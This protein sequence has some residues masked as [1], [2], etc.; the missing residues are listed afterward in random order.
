MSSIFNLIDKKVRDYERNAPSRTTSPVGNVTP[1][2][3]AAPDPRSYTPT[4]TPPA[5]QPQTE[6][7]SLPS[8]PDTDITKT[9]MRG[10]S[11][12][13][14]AKEDRTVGKFQPNSLPAPA[15]QPSMEDI[16]R[17]DSPTG[18]ANGEKYNQSAIFKANKT[19]ET[20]RE[21]GNMLSAE[22]KLSRLEA[23]GDT[24]SKEYF[25][26]AADYYASLEKL[27][28]NTAPAA[29]KKRHQWQNEVFPSEWEWFEEYYRKNFQAIASPKDYDDFMSHYESNPNLPHTPESDRH[30]ATWK[31]KYVSP[32]VGSYGDTYAD[33]ATMYRDMQEIMSLPGEIS[34]LFA[35]VTA[36]GTTNNNAAAS[37]TGSAY[38]KILAYLEK[39]YG[40]DGAAEKTD[41]L[42]SSFTRYANEQ[43]AG[44]RDA[45]ARAAAN[46][47][48]I[49][50]NAA[51]VAAMLGN[52]VTAPIGAGLD[53]VGRMTGL[54]DS[55]YKT[56][57]T[58]LPAYALGDFAGSVRSQTAENIENKVSGPLGEGLSFV[59]N[60]GMSGLD[61]LTRQ[62]IAQAVGFPGLS[63]ALAGSQ[64][65]A[66]GYRDASARG[67]TALQATIMGLA[68]GALE[69]ITEEWSIERLMSLKDMASVKDVVVQALLKSPMSEISEEEL[70]EIG[71]VVADAIFMGKNSKDNI[72]IRNAMA[73]G[74]TYGE[75]VDD[76]W[77]EHGKDL[78]M[79]AA[80][81]YLSTLV[82][83]GP[84]AVRSGAAISRANNVAPMLSEAARAA[85]NAQDAFA[86]QPQNGSLDRAIS[87][88]VQGQEVRS[89][90]EEAAQ[91]RQK[92]DS[93]V[94]AIRT[95]GTV[96]NSVVNS[97]MADNAAMDYLQETAGTDLTAAVTN[98]PNHTAIRDAISA[99]ANPGSTAYNEENTVTGGNKNGEETGAAQGAELYRTSGE[100]VRKL[101]GGSGDNQVLPEGRD[102][103][104]ADIRGSGIVLLSD[105]QAGK[106]NEAGY[107]GAI[108]HQADSDD[109][110][111]SYVD[112]LNRARAD[113]TK[114]GWAVSPKTFEDANQPG[115]KVLL[116]DDGSSG[117]IVTPDG[118][119]E[120]VFANKTAGAKKGSAKYIIA[121][122]VAAGGTKL[123]CYGPAL[124]K[125]YA[126]Y[127][128]VPAS[129]LGFNAEYANDGW[130]ESKGSPDVITMYLAPG[131]TAD[132]ILNG[133][134]AQDI[135]L[136]TVRHYES[137]DYDAAM[138]FRDRQMEA[139]R[140][141]SQPNSY[142]ENTV[143]SA[144]N[145]FPNEQAR[146]RVVDNT[147]TNANDPA[148]REVREAVENA[149]PDIAVYDRIS[150]QES[151][152]NASQRVQTEEMRQTELAELTRDPNSWTG[153]DNDTA[154]M[155]LAHYQ[156]TGDIQSAL[157]IARAQRQANTNAGQLVQSN[158][159]YTRTTTGAMSQAL[160]LLDALRQRDVPR[161]LWR[162][163]GS[164]E[165]W[166]EQQ[167]REILR[168]SN[169]L[170]SASGTSDYLSLIREMARL[171][172]TT[173]RMGSSDNLTK[174]AESVLSGL[175]QENLHDIALRQLMAYPQDFRK[176]GFWKGVSE[177]QA[178]AHLGNFPTADRNLVG[179]LITQIVESFS[180]STS[181]RFLDFLVS[182][183]TG[184][185][186]V[187]NDG[188]QVKAYVQGAN[189]A[190]KLAALYNEL[191]IADTGSAYDRGGPHTFKMNRGPVMRLMGTMDKFL[192]YMLNVSD[193]WFEGGAS[194]STMY[195][196]DEIAH[197]AN[198]TEDER[199]ALA[200]QVAN[201]RTYK[202]DGLL[203]K[204]MVNI[205]KGLNLG[206]DF[207]VG[208]LI[209]KYPRIPGNLGQ[210]AIDYTTGIFKGGA[211][212]A[213]VL[214]DA[215]NGV[216]VDVTAQRKAVSDMARGI[217]GAPLIAILTAAA[218]KKVLKI[219]DDDDKDKKALE[220]AENRTGTVLNITALNRLL[221]GED[222]EEQS[223]DKLV[224]I[225]FLE[226]FDSLMSL[227][228]YLSE[229]EEVTEILKKYPGATLESVAQSIMDLP[230]MS[231]LQD[232]FTTM[233][234][235]EGTTG[236]KALEAAKNTVASGA[237]G[238]IP[239]PI[240]QFASFLDPIA[241]DTSADS[242]FERVVNQAKS[243]IPFLR[244]TLPAKVNP[245]TGQPIED[246]APAALRAYN[247]LVAPGRIY[248]S[249]LS[250][251]ASYMERLATDTD[252]TS[253]YPDRKAPN[254]FKVDGEEL[255]L[256]PEQANAYMT[257]Y[258]TQ[259][260]ALFTELSTRDEFNVLSDEMKVNALG[261]AKQFATASAKAS[262]SDYT[263]NG[264]IQAAMEE[265]LS[266]S[267]IAETIMAKAAGEGANTYE[268]YRSVIANAPEGKI[269]SWLSLYGM[270]ESQLSGLTDAMKKGTSPEDYVNAM[271]SAHNINS[272]W[273]EI[274]DSWKGGK[275]PSVAALE[276]AYANYTSM[277]PANR[278]L[279]E[280][281]LDG[282][283]KA[284][285]HAREKRM[286]T[287]TFM[288]SVQK[289]NEIAASSVSSNDKADKWAAYLDRQIDKGSMTVTQKNAL[290]N[291]LA[292]YQTMRQD[293]D[294][295]YE[296]RAEGASIS[297]AEKIVTDLLAGLDSTTDRWYAISDS[298]L[299][300]ADKEAGFRA[301][302]NDA[303][304]AKM[305]KACDAFDITPVEYVD[306]YRAYREISDPLKGTG[307]VKEPT[308]RGLSVWL[309]NNGFDPSIASAL[310]TLYSGK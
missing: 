49:L 192:S 129:S 301:Y 5:A 1:T 164:F 300:D 85:G 7:L 309:K 118:D 152:A 25:G 299:S 151:L 193:A 121:Q 69:Y 175:S 73:E 211:E 142:G 124:A 233:E 261:L 252:D 15:A 296:A 16:F 186:T 281:M 82:S 64:A 212:I 112:A 102:S 109:A 148:L 256:T 272:G 285:I 291:D 267:D 308:I 201:R 131:V 185:R 270:S 194:N 72:A 239:S 225:G 231:G 304:E 30:F 119:I 167:G 236:E 183:A 199:E 56:A 227:A 94:E 81:T 302:M 165:L 90:E 31:E 238:F 100:G 137:D 163:D 196:L 188:K 166:K 12:A 230:A 263:T 99:I 54:R 241:R 232:F 50:S 43:A 276:D 103:G 173:A 139:A 288:A 292:F 22:Q 206:K 123:D 141:T 157:A 260:G 160:Q 130:D 209:M 48:G 52:A 289:Y 57:D 282:K 3:N 251:L 76:V 155:L 215:H 240:R 126:R 80:S 246:T 65:F 92:V 8:V 259:V 84:E 156:Q 135:D 213:K 277:T 120:G 122:A 182:K 245:A 178:M 264:W 250:P 66:S 116:S 286:T 61:N 184:K 128:F 179:N 10:L 224:S 23:S 62:T 95:G 37:R 68:E 249:R 287:E 18:N 269:E 223:G 280:G 140:G 243:N 71:G 247:S 70:S 207:G 169:S 125:I 53:A 220:S 20:R 29:E 305:D 114:N 214:Y 134:A 63:M 27:E 273:K 107:S 255:K 6:T 132:D 35:Q 55:R 200:E 32:D 2:G 262:I 88:T 98:T 254:S 271:E 274:T 77:K 87:A 217:T 138:S 161:R 89:P 144:Q 26:A 105:S 39:E 222:A 24:K 110:K 127:G 187:G 104:P 210:M 59:Y 244:E 67:G 290:L 136:S 170:E 147:L 158:A 310:Y 253:F 216:A 146:S 143:G 235:A 97:I 265:G 177:V 115:N 91:A 150:E 133:T 307:E 171:R 176:V 203:A 149:D 4:F 41:Q 218:A 159:K 154:M 278:R 237:A 293:A 46:E 190:A 294:K 21:A 79:T 242:Q 295:Y 40:K 168:L 38:S 191:D 74:K 9:M 60:A 47:H 28:G 14:V 93:A 268:K 11:F 197:V 78:L 258:G 284:Y 106:V 180:D 219:F 279:V 226:P 36:S 96:S 266:V 195:S 44:R 111:Q 198:L 86:A 45:D 172:G 153:E 298:S 283:E 113:D 19:A 248:E 42:I 13:P 303:Q 17:Y 101:P 228:V 117:A 297:G 181:A 189:N 221:H 234:Y 162:E 205:K 33:R 108:L 257:E 306:F 34:N 51:S 208:D 275:E 145:P 58:N 204:G 229:E 174:V 202:E 75:A 83:Q